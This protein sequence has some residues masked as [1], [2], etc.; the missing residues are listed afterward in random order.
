MPSP[1]SLKA[2]FILVNDGRQDTTSLP[3]APKK[4]TAKTALQQRFVLHL[5]FA[6]SR[7]SYSTSQL[8]HPSNDPSYIPGSIPSYAHDW[9]R[10]GTG[11]LR[12]QT[13]FHRRLRARLQLMRSEPIRVFEEVG[14]NSVHLAYWKSIT[15]LFHSSPA[16]HDHENFPGDHK[17]VT[18]VGRP[19]PLEE[20]PEHFARLRRWG[21]TFSKRLLPLLFQ[22]PW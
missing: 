19:F 14:C 9:S 7:C 5:V 4:V 13:T 16:D 6:H 18:F 21:L 2:S 17:F 3:V 11:G 10:N 8:T 15:I 12:T 20:A 1:S 22:L